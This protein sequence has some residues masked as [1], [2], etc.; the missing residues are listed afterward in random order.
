M[1]KPG[2]ASVAKL[3]LRL[4]NTTF[5][6]GDP[7]MAG[8]QREL[9]HRREWLTPE[10]HGL[11]YGLARVTPGTNVLAYCAATGWM[12]LGVPGALLAVMG[13]CVPTAVIAAWFCG[14]YDSYGG[15]RY[16]QAAIGG[17]VASAVGMMASSGLSLVR[18]RLRPGWIALGLFLV[19]GAIAVRSAG[20]LS[21][22]KVL[23]LA[24]FLGALA[25]DRK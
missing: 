24:A 16:F 3:Y 5:G 14:V 7:T 21:P 20:L 8:L 4:G 23:A 17:V 1:T 12:L 6:G 19:I 18:S 9:V 13:V 2:F 10:Q 22:L 25:G 15:N 11:A